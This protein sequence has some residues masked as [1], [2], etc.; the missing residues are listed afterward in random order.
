MS[1]LRPPPHGLLLPQQPPRGPSLRAAA[2]VRPRGCSPARRGPE[3][4]RSPA[5][6]RGCQATRHSRP[7][8][9][10]GRSSWSRERSAPG[11]RRKAGS[12]SRAGAA[13]QPPA[14]RPAAPPRAGLSRALP[15]AGSRRRRRRRRPGNWGH[16]PAILCSPPPPR[17]PGSRSASRSSREPVG[18]RGPAGAR[19]G[20]AEARACGGGS[21]TPARP[22][23]ARRPLPAARLPRPAGPA[24]RRAPTRG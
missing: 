17:L 13:P 19:A 22:R 1:P 9:S 10:S 12:A 14:A 3:S 23:A 4:A 6:L 11:E 7:S 21:R 24:P 2:E 16:V 15:S 20:R 18:A 8:A 5:A